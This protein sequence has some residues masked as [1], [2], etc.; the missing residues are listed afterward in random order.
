MKNIYKFITHI[1]ANSFPLN[2]YSEGEMKKLMEKFKEEADD[3]GIDITDVQLKKY[4]ERFDQIK[5]SP[6]IQEKDL[7]KWT[8]PNLI[9]LV[10]SSEGADE[11][12]EE[13]PDVLYSGDG[14]TVYSGG[15]EELCRRH[16]DDVPWCITRGSFGNY[17]YNKS[18]NYPSF[19]LIKNTN[20]PESN[21]LSFVAIQVRDEDENSK[22]VWTPRDN[23]PN[24]S[25][26][27]GWS[28]LTSDIPWLENIPNIRS[29]LKNIS[30]SSKEKVTQ[31]YGKAGNEVSIRKWVNMP[32][33]E[34]KQYLVARKTTSGKLFSDISDS[35]F[36]SNYLPKYPQ[37][38]TFAAVTPGLIEP[39]L[40]LKNLDKF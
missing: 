12:E 31:V 37:L 11:E 3:F 38:A 20:L 4:I 34:K 26:P 19:Y 35:E 28:K 2:E 30:L 9:K 16:R 13:G 18:K 33:N 22:Y 27:M 39:M 40:L 15:N 25:S 6:K 14:Y 1:V 5:G 21:K 24:E 36:V 8:L 7:R 17:R 23:S 32:F 10:S 29:M